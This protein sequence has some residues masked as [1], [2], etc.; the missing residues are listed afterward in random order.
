MAEGSEVQNF[1]MRGALGGKISP[2]QRGPQG[3]NFAMAEGPSGAKFRNGRE[4]LGGKISPWK[5][6]PR[7]PNF[8]MTEGP[9]GQ[10]F[11]MAEGPLGAKFRPAQIS[12]Q[13]IKVMRMPSVG[14][15]CRLLLPRGP[16]LSSTRWKPLAG[17]HNHLADWRTI[18]VGW[19]G[20]PFGWLVEISCL[21]AD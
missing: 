14:Q 20:Q 8:A 3:P 18:A 7:E 10:N 19:W 16:C 6:V 9:T 2:W 13:R 21:E 1:A 12:L 15:I 11:A 4:A 17:R 5:R